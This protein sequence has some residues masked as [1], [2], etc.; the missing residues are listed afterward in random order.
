MWGGGG[1]SQRL[2]LALLLACTHLVVGH[3]SLLGSVRGFP[4]PSPHDQLSLPT[5][6]HAQHR[7]A[8]HGG[9]RGLGRTP[10]RAVDRCD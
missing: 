3:R 10:R 2:R 8:I 6:P 4:L 7:A 9:W 5:I 1:R